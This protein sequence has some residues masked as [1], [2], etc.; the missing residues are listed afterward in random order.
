VANEIGVGAARDWLAMRGGFTF[1]IALFF[2]CIS[3]AIG[4]LVVALGR[5]R[6]IVLRAV[7]GF[8][9]G[10]VPT[11]IAV[12]VAA[13][14]LHELGVG[15]FFALAFGYGMLW[16]I[17]SIFERQDLRARVVVSVLALHSLLDGSSLAIA[18]HFPSARASL[19]LVVAI[20][21]HRLPEGMVV[22]SMV[23]PRY[24]VRAAAA[25]ASLLG[26]TMILGAWGGRALLRYTDA[27]A[28]S[29][30]VVVGM[31]ALLRAIFHG[32]GIASLRSRPALTSAALGVVVALAADR[33]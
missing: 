2:S 11:L 32:D 16:A 20:V 19:M 28:L 7:E 14:M 10:I 30:V 17:E 3:L 15:F 6:A 9:V 18:E 33:I 1:A 31:G 26:M 5:G 27:R 24:G 12:H 25:G 8:V 29:V 13:T 23:I 22:A 4:V 21:L